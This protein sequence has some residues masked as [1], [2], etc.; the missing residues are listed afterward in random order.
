MGTERI[1]DGGAAA[2]ARQAAEAARRAAEAAA[3]QAAEAARKAAE[4]AAKQ[5]AAAARKVAEG[6]KNQ[7]SFEP[8]GAKNKLKL[9]GQGAPSST[10]FNENSKDSKVNCLDKAADFVSKS[11]PEL[12]SRSDLVF[13]KDSRP[14]AEGQSGH[15]VVRQG[16]RVLDPSNGKSYEDMPAYLKDQPHYSEAGTLSGTS[17]AKIFSTEAGS[18]E[19][20]QALADAN[21]S[22]EL[23]KMM[24]ADSPADIGA[25]P[26]AATTEPHEIKIPGQAGPVEVEFSDTLEKDVKKEDGYVTVSITAETSV[27]ATGS[28]EFK[29][30]K[31]GVGASVEGSVEAG[32]TMTY[33]V[34]M[35]EADY[36]KLKAGEIAPPHP[37]NAETIPD[38]ASV[39]MEQSQFAGYG[40]D[41]GLSYHAAELGISGDV[42]SGK[43][44]S[45]EVSRNGDKLS[46]T[47]GPTEFIENN[48]K[49]SLGVGPVSVSVGR[50]DTLK[51]YKLRT[52][53]FDLSNPDGKKAY[54]AFAKDGRMPEKEGPGVANTLRFD[55]INYE[56]TGGK[57]G[58]DVGPFSIES[59]GTTNTGEYLI[60]H[61][62]DGTKSMTSDITY[63]GDH[64]DIT[65]EQKY[66]TDGKLIPG[67]E[68]FAMKFDTTDDNARELL[69]YSYTGDAEKAKAARE[70]DRPITLNL[71][72]DD[73]KELQR[74]SGI[75]AENGGHMGINMILT[76]YDGKPTDALWAV[77]T[78]ACSPAYNE[79][80]L[81]ES[82]FGL[83]MDGGKQP[84]P[85]EL[86]IG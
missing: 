86:V 20:A 53:E 28:V 16:E 22:P 78:M 1:G 31:V 51:E 48:G 19:R 21:V 83:F 11:S 54:E 44:M 27:S 17:A 79:Y 39:K 70:H 61:H 26:N 41:V 52:A 75:Q 14:G 13:L 66:G 2:A 74:R 62:P 4:A 43:G 47:A 6:L 46:M 72:P 40:L 85:G 7:S 38:G 33:E 80:K 25:A 9:D 37:L 3:R 42:K 35:K 77:R 15:V 55:K 5:A 34:K 64:P 69:V 24:V 49:V 67:S 63:G 71:T 45:I 50:S 29:K 36:E 68:K 18:P 12:Q 57:V 76:D 60:T 82:Y 81:A 56:S 58:I 84:L 8:A 10:L 32:K 73:V 30:A 65:I 23:Q 59:D